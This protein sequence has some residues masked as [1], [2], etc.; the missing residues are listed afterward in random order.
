MSMYKII[1]ISNRAMCGNFLERVK[2]ISNENIPVVLR[3]KDLSESGYELLARRVMEFC[4]EVILHT[5]IDAAYRLGC[6]K[7]H[8]PI[9]ILRAADLSGFALIG[10]SIHSVEEA[11]EAQ[12]LGASYITAGH[13]F[14][15]DCKKGI[16]PRG[17]GFLKSVCEAVEIPVFAIGGIS[18]ENAGAAVEAGAE[19]VCVMSGLMK[20]GNVKEYLKLFN[21]GDNYD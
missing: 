16:P 2:E 7:I 11:V 19:G 9:Q 6:K 13:I 17:V 14:A 1:S 5:Y 18:P 21:T 20:C 15:T 8:L 10:A 12:K 4:P 3:E